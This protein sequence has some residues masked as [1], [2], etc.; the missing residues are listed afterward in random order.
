MLFTDALDELKSIALY[1]SSI[2][3]LKEEIEIL[4]NRF[5]AHSPALTEKVGG[6]LSRD[7]Q[8][9]NTITHKEELES[10]LD[11]CRRTR[12]HIVDKILQLDNA[13]ERLVLYYRYVTRNTIEQIADKLDYEQRQIYRIHNRAVE[14]YRN[15]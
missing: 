5:N 6:G 1:D 13:T 9:I 4:D 3:I 10:E 12:K 14:S 15:L 8:L 7:N 2:V 11:N